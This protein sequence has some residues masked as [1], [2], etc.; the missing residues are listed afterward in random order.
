M[1]DSLAIVPVAPEVPAPA[2]KPS[3]EERFRKIEENRELRKK[4]AL[5]LEQTRQLEEA[6][7]KE[8]LDEAEHQLSLLLKKEELAKQ[9]K[10][11]ASKLANI[12]KEAKR[13]KDNI[14]KVEIPFS[15]GFGPD[16]LWG[17]QMEESG[18]AGGGGGGGGGGGASTRI[19]A[20]VA[21]DGRHTIEEKQSH[22]LAISSRRVL[23][24]T[25][26]MCIHILRGN[27]CHTLD[28]KNMHPTGY[29]LGP[30]TFC[31][32]GQVCR[33]KDL[34]LA[35][36]GCKHN[37]NEELPSNGDFVPNSTTA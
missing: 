6:E 10:S 31:S 14:K 19:W 27:Y 34:P 1:S 28:C 18:G 29:E 21:S 15:F 2:Q 35:E 3:M 23:P 26:R 12:E 17:D 13:A 16:G 24:T 8:K 11:N 5:E 33:Y 4:E 20:K 7:M 30:R 25:G 37:H 9:I 22:T 36:G 32:Y